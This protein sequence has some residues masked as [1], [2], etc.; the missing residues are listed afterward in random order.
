MSSRKKNL[1]L[2]DPK[3]HSE[4]TE[5][6]KEEMK[7]VGLTQLQLADAI[8]MERS[9][10]SKVMN[11]K[12]LPSGYFLICLAQQ[13]WDVG[14]ILSGNGKRGDSLKRIEQLEFY[15]EQ[16]ERLVKKEFK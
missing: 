14:Y 11:G 9:Y 8:G 4:I 5:R 12:A 6:M 7:K 2:I 13:G 10:I 1:E 3:L 16:L 15:V